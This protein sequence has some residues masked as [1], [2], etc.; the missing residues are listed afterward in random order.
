MILLYPSIVQS[1]LCGF[2][3]SQSFFPL[4]LRHCVGEYNYL[5][6]NKRSAERFLFWIKQSFSYPRGKNHSTS[7]EERIHFIVESLDTVVLLLVLAGCILFWIYWAVPIY[8]LYR[9]ARVHTQSCFA[10]YPMP[11]NQFEQ[12]LSLLYILD[13]CGPALTVTYEPWLFLWGSTVKVEYRWELS[14][15]Y[16]HWSCYFPPLFLCP[17][18]LAGTLGKCWRICLQR[19]LAHTCT[20]VTSKWIYQL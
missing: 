19:I 14:H 3:T 2:P 16:K 10:C 13:S 9:R 6:K 8:S 5:L 15:I 12:S 20:T 18:F 11:N 7:Y 4:S 17:P 1:Y